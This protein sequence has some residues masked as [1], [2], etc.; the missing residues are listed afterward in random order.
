MSPS[1]FHRDNPLPAAVIRQKYE[2]SE[3]TLSLWSQH[4]L[5]LLRVGSNVFVRESEVVRFIETGGNP[6]RREAL[7]IRHHAKFLTLHFLVVALA[8][9]EWFAWLLA[10]RRFRLRDRID[11]VQAYE[12]FPDEP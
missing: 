8:P 4:G 12:E 5:P 11:R 1:C 10:E 3:E 6:R 9:W 2:L 7:T